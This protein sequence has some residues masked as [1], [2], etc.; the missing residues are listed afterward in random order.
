[1][2]IINQK[3]NL[4]KTNKINF[5]ILVSFILKVASGFPET[6]NNYDDEYIIFVKYKLLMNLADILTHILEITF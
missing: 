1:M 6:Q 3:K 5:K 2:I 4:S